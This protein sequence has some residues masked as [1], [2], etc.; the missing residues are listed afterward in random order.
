MGFIRK[1]WDVLRQPSAKYSL[2]VL[3]GGGLVAGAVGI[4]FFNFVMLNGT[5]TTE[6]CATSCH[7]MSYAY[8]EWKESSH[9]S[10]RTGVQAGCADCH[11]PHAK[12]FGG[13]ID[14]I[15]AKM[16][17]A[18]DTYHYIMGT[19]DTEEKYEAGRWT[20][21][22]SVWARMKAR[23]SK[24]CRY[25]H[26]IEAMKLSVQDRSARRKHARAMK[27]GETCIDCHK[28]IVHE[29]PDE[30]EEEEEETADE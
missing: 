20:M 24:E 17:A 11:V 25:C 8:E 7:E 22:N 1:M 12:D 5:S 27:S 23:D 9:S 18:K 28:G 16:Q 4:L 29:E 13:W 21:A 10:N 6:F 3:L 2:G 14:K 15:L 26:N 19:Y 30:P